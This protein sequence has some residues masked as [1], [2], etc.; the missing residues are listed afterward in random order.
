MRNEKRS[1]FS[2]WNL[3]CS[4]TA[5]GWASFPLFNKQEKRGDAVHCKATACMAAAEL[6]RATAAIPVLKGALP[7]SSTALV[8]HGPPTA[9]G[10]PNCRINWRLVGYGVKAA[11]NTVRAAKWCQN[12]PTFAVNWCYYCKCTH[13]DPSRECKWLIR[14]ISLEEVPGWPISDLM[15]IHVPYRHGEP[16]LHPSTAWALCRSSVWLRARSYGHEGHQ[17]CGTQT[18]WENAPTVYAL[19]WT[20]GDEGRFWLEIIWQKLNISSD[21]RKK[22]P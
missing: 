15:M 7:R 3:N 13:W 2:E 8:S 11:Q 19:Q 10:S 20:A 21:L 17:R 1:D 22:N 14:V 18:K 5:R 6:P 12:P 16:T 9:P 4:P